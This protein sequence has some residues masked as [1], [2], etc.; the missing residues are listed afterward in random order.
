MIAKEHVCIVG[1]YRIMLFRS[2]KALSSFSVSHSNSWLWTVIIT[3]WQKYLPKKPIDCIWLLMWKA[4]RPPFYWN[5]LLSVLLWNTFK[6]LTTSLRITSLKVTLAPL[7][8]QSF[9][10]TL[11]NRPTRDITP[12]ATLPTSYCRYVSRTVPTQSQGGFIWIYQAYC[13]I[14]EKTCSP[15]VLQFIADLYH[16]NSTQ[17]DMSECP[18]NQRNHNILMEKEWKMVQSLLFSWKRLQQPFM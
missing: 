12:L 10:S 16:R 5:L 1:K 8:I 14:L 18:G 15:S 13:N 2:N 6:T 17:L 4:K 9:R 7:N 11:H 3:V